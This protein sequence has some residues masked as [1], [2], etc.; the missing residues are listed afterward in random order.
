[1][2]QALV[3]KGF[4]RTPTA[5]VQIADIR[6]TLRRSTWE[7]PPRQT[8]GASRADVATLFAKDPERHGL[9]AVVLFASAS[10][11]A[12]VLKL[13]VR[14]VTDVGDTEFHLRMRA[15]KTNSRGGPAR[16]VAIVLPPRAARHLRVR[17]RALQSDDKI[18]GDVSYPQF[19]RFVKATNP[20]LAAHAFRRGGIQAAM[21]AQI[22]DESVMRLSGHK[23]LESLATYAGTLP[24]SWRLQMLRTSAA[25]MLV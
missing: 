12:D 16:T 23:T 18:F 4:S 5:A 25:I 10:R 21:A 8:P 24:R 13:T 14:D 6:D 17:L 20:T 2:E 22:D 15:E 3:R 19:L 11:F 7:E 9:M 1:V